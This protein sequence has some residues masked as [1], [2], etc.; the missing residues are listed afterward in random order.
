M[1]AGAS[2][3]WRFGDGTYGDDPSHSARRFL[4][5]QTFTDSVIALNNYVLSVKMIR[6]SSDEEKVLSSLRLLPGN[7]S[8]RFLEYLYS[9]CRS[10][11]KNATSF[12]I[13]AGKVHVDHYAYVT[14]LEFRLGA[15]APATTHRQC[16]KGPARLDWS[17]GDVASEIAS[18][19]DAAIGRFLD[20]SAR[21][22]L[23]DAA[24]MKSAPQSMPS[25]TEL[26]STPLLP[27][28]PR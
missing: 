27:R 23:R 15:A 2:L 25:L 14:M 20:D 8:S 12:S 22:L 4:S 17:R 24:K 9:F 5:D 26:K 11:H 18:V 6:D 13:Y 16:P 7:D 1:Q 3:T 28:V 10:E 21:N 19:T